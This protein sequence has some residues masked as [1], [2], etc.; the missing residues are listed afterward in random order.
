M[1][2]GVDIQGF[3]EGIDIKNNYVYVNL[4]A[5]VVDI[6]NDKWVGL[7]IRQTASA[8]FVKQKNNFVQGESHENRRKHKL[9]EYHPPPLQAR[10]NGQTMDVRMGTLALEDRR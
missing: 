5:T 4:D 2:A 6:S 9:P 7:H 1:I 8:I 10:Q 3:S